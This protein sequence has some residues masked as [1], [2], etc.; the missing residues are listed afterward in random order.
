MVGSDRRSNTGM[1]FTPTCVIYYFM[2]YF[3]SDPRRVCNSCNSNPYWWSDPCRDRDLSNVLENKGGNKI[4][5]DL[6]ILKKYGI[7]KYQEYK[8]YVGEGSIS[9]S[10]AF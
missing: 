10:L 5:R 4:M 8:L 7:E 6:E 1:D 3:L 2:E 9:F